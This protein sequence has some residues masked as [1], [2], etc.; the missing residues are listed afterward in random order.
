M[1]S[2]FRGSYGMLT[3][4]LASCA[5]KCLEILRVNTW[6]SR[7]YYESGGADAPE[8]ASQEEAQRRYFRGVY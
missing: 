3:L 8:S 6:H 1:N 5:I 7:T 2:S 4:N